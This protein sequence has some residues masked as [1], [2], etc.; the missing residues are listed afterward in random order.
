MIGNP[1][2]GL[3]REIDRRSRST[4]RRGRSPK[5]REEAVPQPEPAE[6]PPRVGAVVVTGLDGRARVE[7]ASASFAGAPVLTAAPVDPA[8]SD[9][10]VTV[11][12]VVEKVDQAA[13]VVRVWRLGDVPLSPAGPGIRVH[14]TAAVQDA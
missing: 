5:P 1:M 7:Y 4:T 9:D 3:L 6:L 2:G 14:V 12:A 11:F 13:A 10:A 8:P